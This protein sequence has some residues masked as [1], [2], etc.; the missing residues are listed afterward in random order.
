[1]NDELPK[2]KR[3]WIPI[4]IGVVVLIGFL[5]IGA[6]AITISWFRQNL[7][8]SD[9]T[10]TSATEQF[11]AVRAKYPGQ[12][13]L[14]RLV[15][16]QPQ[17][18]ADRAGQAPTSTPL[19]TLHV[20]AFDRDKGKVVTFSLPMWLLRM[21]SGPIRISAYQQGWDDR[22]VS[23]NIEDIEKHGPGIIV[24]ATERRQGRALLWVD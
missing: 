13:P 8:T 22:G 17:F 20:L 11:D 15:D 18:D 23:F 2:K 6:I 4:V 12:Q 21:K 16:G 9:A 10:E 14:I 5:A 1:M 7:V 24:D 19:T 3:S